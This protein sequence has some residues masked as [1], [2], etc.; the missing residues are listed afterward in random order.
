M[1]Q[2][3]AAHKENARLDALDRLQI[4]HSGYEQP[5][6]RIVRMV[7]NLFD[8]PNVGIHLLDD[9]NQWVKAFEGQRFACPRDQSVC[10]FI[11]EINELMVIPDLREDVRT[12]EL[13][14]VSG[15]PHLR[16]YAGMPLITSDGYTVGTL[17]LIDMQPRAGLDKA[18]QTQ[19]QEFAALITEVMELRVHYQR[20]AQALH[21]A[22]EFDA[23]TGLYNRV[24]LIREGQRL[25]G[26][27]GN[28]AATA[29]IKVRLD[30]MNLVLG[31]FGQQGG[32]AVMQTIAGRLSALSEPP[33]LLGRG[34]GN[35][36]VLIRIGT[37]TD[38]QATLELWLNDMAS[39]ILTAVT[40]PIALAEHS[41]NLTASLGL[42]LMDNNTAVYHVVDAAS[43]ASLGS[44]ELGGNQARRFSAE[45]FSA[46]RDR[47][48][49]E[50]ELRKAFSEQLFELHYQPI[51][52][53]S[54]QG[55]IRGAEALIRWPR[56]G[57]LPIGPDQFIPVAEEIGIISEL[58]LWVFSTACRDLAS[59]Q[60]GRQLWIAVNLSPVQLTDPQLTDKLVSRAQAAGVSCSQ[61]KLE[62]TE[63][64]LETEY[65][66]V[67][68]TLRELHQAGFMLAVDDFGTG[69]SSM[70]RVIRMP[71]D[72]L[73][74]DRGFVSDC[75][76]G[77]GAAVVTSMGALADQL[78]M[79][80]IAEG[81]ETASQEAFLLQHGY[82]LAQGYRY[83]R[84]MPADAFSNYLNT[85]P[86]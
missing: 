31:S 60:Q 29:V 30:R 84:P 39:R 63:G 85:S 8:V 48:N 23:V 76:D 58:G 42:A 55:Q 82:R 45:E 73:K 83:A 36:F 77:A 9:S 53:M 74:V 14:I 66:S 80:L 49:I 33:V 61:I 86:S 78:N 18:Q 81:V 64:A 3:N 21:K 22:T 7:A 5:F 4:M 11:L 50:A 62:I 75:P 1:P 52:D 34:N 51:I 46:F 43:A 38:S 67:S 59:W 69:H 54:E 57:N 41:I 25:L 72:A 16:F 17:C 15:P 13:A 2:D 56:P 24:A 27:A 47:I 12:R 35:N 28:D 44:R 26:Q 79:E 19:F 37:D 20:T 40:Q 10:Q 65:D 6:D 68:K 70:N 71:F 32:L